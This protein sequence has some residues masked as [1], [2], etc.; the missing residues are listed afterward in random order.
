MKE[1][2][3]NNNTILCYPD[4]DGDVAIEVFNGSDGWITQYVPFDKLAAWVDSV[5]QENNKKNCNGR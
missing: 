4:S 5:R 3:V 1:L 2:D